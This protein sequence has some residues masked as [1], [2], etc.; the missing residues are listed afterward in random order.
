MACAVI[1]ST[2]PCSA[3]ANGPRSGEHR[4]E[5][6]EQ[7]CEQDQRA[8][9]R[10]QQHPVQPGMYAVAAGFGQD[11]GAGDGV[12][13]QPQ[14]GLIDVRMGRLGDARFGLRDRLGQFG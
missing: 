12:R 13:G 11:R 1:Q 9:P 4:L 7:Q 6:H 14:F 2:P 10:V 3:S 8:Q 5:H